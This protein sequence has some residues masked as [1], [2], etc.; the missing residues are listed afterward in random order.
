MN[1]LRETARN[2]RHYFAARLICNAVFEQDI[3]ILNEIV[4]RI[5]GAVPDKD[6]RTL[7]ANLLGDAIE[8]VLDRETADQM[9][10][11]PDDPTIIALAK[12]VVWMAVR[13]VG[14]NVQ[15]KKDRHKAASIVLDRT[16]GKRSE[17]VRDV[18]K[19]DYVEP[20]WMKG[21]PNGS[22]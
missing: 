16:G 14:N 17:P 9:S 5:D 22:E 13:S 1:K 7:F 3:D 20:D 2:A 18:V 21:L 11:D 4:K 8:D 10:L 6:D 12:V 19:L 15:A